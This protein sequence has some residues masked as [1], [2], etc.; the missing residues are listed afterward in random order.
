MV[1]LFFFAF[2]LLML[3][4]QYVL[5]SFDRFESAFEIDK[6][7]KTGSKGHVVFSHIS[8][9][10][11]WLKSDQTYSLKPFLFYAILVE[12]ELKPLEGAKGAVKYWGIW[13]SVL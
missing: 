2:I 1:Y 6:G 13:R 10:S 8:P 7:K 9:L 12:G 5:D 11:V 4:I 3:Y